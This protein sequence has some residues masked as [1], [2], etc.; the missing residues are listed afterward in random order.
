LAGLEEQ[1]KKTKADVKWVSPENLHLTLKFLGDIDEEQFKKISELL[2]DVANNHSS[3]TAKIGSI[4]AFPKLS[5]LKVVWVG[6]TMGDEETKKIFKE[7]K[8][9]IEKLGIPKDDRAFSSHITLGRTR[10]P[11]NRKD[12]AKEIRKISEDFKLDNAEFQVAKL[13]LFQSTLSPTGPTYEVLKAA[14][15]KTT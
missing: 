1:L 6:I 2:D 8:E 10:S 12:L 4:G 3:Y 9:R 13:T 5:L 7:L 11:N 15:L 14:N